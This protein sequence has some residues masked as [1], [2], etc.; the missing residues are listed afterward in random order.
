MHT[1]CL[2]REQPAHLVLCVVGKAVTPVIVDAHC[3]AFD[4]LTLAHFIFDFKFV[5]SIGMFCFEGLDST[6][7]IIQHAS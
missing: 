2:H 7:V 3:K 4:S 6:G 5:T 1:C